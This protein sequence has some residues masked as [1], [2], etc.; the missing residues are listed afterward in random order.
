MSWRAVCW[1]LWAKYRKLR[2]APRLCVVPYLVNSLWLPLSCSGPHR[3]HPILALSEGEFQEQLLEEIVGIKDSF[4]ADQKGNI[5]IGCFQGNEKLFFNTE[6]FAFHTE[7]EV[8][9]SVLH[10]YKFRVRWVNLNSMQMG[11]RIKHFHLYNHCNMQHFTMRYACHFR[12]ES[13]HLT[14]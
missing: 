4:I 3:S 12:K 2:P 13:C 9:G 6:I 5:F 1:V 11:V 14:M 8:C 7:M 10:Q